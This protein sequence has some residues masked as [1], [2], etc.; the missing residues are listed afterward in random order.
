MILF[1]ITAVKTSN[2]TNYI[3]TLKKVSKKKSAQCIKATTMK[4]VKDSII[5]IHNFILRFHH[6]LI[7]NLSFHP[8]Q[9]HKLE[10]STILLLRMDDIPFE[11]QHHLM[12]N[13]SSPL[14]M[15]HNMYDLNGVMLV[16]YTLT[17]H[18]CYWIW[19]L[20]NKTISINVSFI[21]GYYVLSPREI[22]IK[23]LKGRES[24]EFVTVSSDKTS[25]SSYCLSV[26]FSHNP[27]PYK[28]LSFARQS[29]HGH[30]FTFIMNN[31]K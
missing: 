21:F 30:K 17:T 14:R 12:V 13:S 18:I 5:V 22:N 25:I 31:Y 20:F 1:I 6:L 27:Q 11:Y 28:L 9:P 8:L 29:V 15:P 23:S 4:I 16:S 10:Q 3:F 19:V 26:P 7:S 24:M 2:P